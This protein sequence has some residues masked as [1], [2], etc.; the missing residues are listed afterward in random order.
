LAVQVLNSVDK[1]SRM[2][3]ARCLNQILK[4]LPSSREKEELLAQLGK[5]TQMVQKFGDKEYSLLSALGSHNELV[6]Q[7]AIEVLTQKPFVAALT[8]NERAIAKLFLVQLS[9]NHNSDEQLLL[10][11]LEAF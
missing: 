6:R 9:I 8:E 4:Q 2:Q 10:Q 1:S 3:Y 5:G 11:I 7:K